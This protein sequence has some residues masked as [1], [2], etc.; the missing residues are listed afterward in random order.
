MRIA[1]LGTGTVGRSLASR[2][3]YKDHEVTLGTRDI[4]VTTGRTTPDPSGN[5][6]LSEWLAIQR[7]VRVATVTAATERADLVINAV[8]GESVIAALELA[9]D[10]NLA[11]KVLLDVSNGLNFS[12][13]FPPKLLV[14]NT[15]SLGEQIERAFPDARVVKS[16]N[17][18]NASLMLSPMQVAGGDHTVFVAGDD[19][20]AKATVKELLESFGWNDIIDLG[21]ISASRGAEMLLPAWLLLSQALETTQFQFKIAR[22]HRKT[23]TRC[24]GACAKSSRG[25]GLRRKPGSHQPCPLTDGRAPRR[26]GGATRATVVVSQNP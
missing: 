6:P 23:G 4:E 5:P 18:M 9:G 21:G 12:E 25:V 19:K 10:E 26:R 15:D 16:M 8:S 20:G 3:A 2:L 24:G 7:G 22:S 14:A 17:T 11:F 13:G 1:V